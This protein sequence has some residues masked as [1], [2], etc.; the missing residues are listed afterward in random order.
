MGRT[1]ILD[2]FKDMPNY[3]KQT[4]EHNAL[5]DAKWNKELHKFIKTL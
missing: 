5:C 3:P 1:H 2:A 4:N